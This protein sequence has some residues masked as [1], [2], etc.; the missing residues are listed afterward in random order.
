M[1]WL[2]LVLTREAS[3][4]SDKVS[5]ARALSEWCTDTTAAQTVHGHISTWDVSAVTDL[6][7]LVYSAPCRSTFNEDINAWEVGP[8]TNMDV[9]CHLPPGSGRVGRGGARWL[10]DSTAG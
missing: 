8:V 5:L 10:W 7:R 1:L 2:C 9:R 6:Q 4:M 3:A